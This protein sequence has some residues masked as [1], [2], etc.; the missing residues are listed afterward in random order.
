MKIRKGTFETNSSSTHSIAISK[1]KVNIPVG[2]CVNFYIGEY[3]WDEGE[4]DFP[5]YM[6]TAL[7][8]NNDMEAIEKLKSIL[9][10]WGVKYKFANPKWQSYED[11]KYLD[12]GYI[13]HGEEAYSIMTEILNDEDLLARALFGDSTVYTGNDNSSEEDSMCYCAEEYMWDFDKHMEVPNPNH[14]PDKYDYFFKGN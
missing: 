6:Y 9:D 14:M 4:Y 11:Y 13:D 1:N 12:N 8:Y 7:L 10:S 3:G 2:T 5:S